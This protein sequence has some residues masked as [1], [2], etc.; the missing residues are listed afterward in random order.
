M[1]EM[2]A[3]KTTGAI[4]VCSFAACYRLNFSEGL[5]GELERR[6]GEGA[7]TEEEEEEEED[8]GGGGGTGVG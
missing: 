5:T 6:E 2:K 1:A 8:S 7:A 3:G 4:S